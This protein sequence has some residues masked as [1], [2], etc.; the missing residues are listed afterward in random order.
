MKVLAVQAHPDDEVLWA[1]PVLQDK[2]N[3]RYL[4]TVSDNR[5]GYGKRSLEALRE[6]CQAEDIMLCECVMENS[7]FYRLPFRYAEYTLTN[8][9]LHIKAAIQ[10]SIDI[11]KPNYIWTHNPVGEYG[12]GDH[13]LIFD[14]VAS[15]DKPIL[16]SDI[17]LLNSCHHS[18]ND[19]PGHVESAWYSTYNKEIEL[20]MDFYGRCKAI[21]EKHKAWSWSYE[22]VKETS[23]Y[24]IP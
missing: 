22:P 15:L 20:D 17:C 9:I 7:E 23:I 18:F 13:R 8:A 4:V 12:H 5:R 1:W 10:R 14:I 3:E 24:A 6:V 19:I 11:V 21:Y 2:A 16:F